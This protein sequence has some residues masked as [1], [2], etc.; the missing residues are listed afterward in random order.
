MIRYYICNQPILHNGEKFEVGEKIELE[1]K[2]AQEL[3]G[4]QAIYPMPD[5]QPEQ[6]T[7]PERKRG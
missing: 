5:P 7:V 4:L 2:N 6:A 1:Q 3:L